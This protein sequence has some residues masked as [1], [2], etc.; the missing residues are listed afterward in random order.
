MSSRTKSL[1]LIPLSFPLRITLTFSLEIS[2]SLAMVFFAFLSWMMPIKVL[3]TAITKKVSS[4]QRPTIKRAMAMARRSLLKKVKTLPEII[5]HVVFELS[6]TVLTKWFGSSCR[7]TT[8]SFVNPWLISG[9]NRSTSGGISLISRPRFTSLGSLLSSSERGFSLS[10]SFVSSVFFGFLTNI[11]M[12]PLVF[13]APDGVYGNG[14]RRT[15]WHR[16]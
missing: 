5:C 3:A 1:T 11:Q 9:L 13:L 12:Y 16:P 10:I 7:L 8:C 15:P 4:C 6:L 14:L 2:F